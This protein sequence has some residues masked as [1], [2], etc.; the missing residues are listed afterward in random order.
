MATPE[1]TAKLSESVKEMETW[2]DRYTGKTA[3]Y[4]YS[5][6]SAK[7]LQP[8]GVT[9]A[10]LQGTSVAAVRANTVGNPL[11]KIAAD[12]VTQ[13]ATQAT[14]KLVT[15]SF[16]KLN[17]APIQNATQAV[18]QAWAAYSNLGTEI[19]MELARNAAKTI[20]KNNDLRAN[21]IQSIQTDLVTLHNC[22][23]VILNS[24]PFL[25][26]LVADEVADRLG[27]VAIAL[28]FVALVERAE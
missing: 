1:V 4:V 24:S 9:K 15:D 11:A 27:A 12:T 21:L 20:V 26:K 18:F 16:K 7:K 13:L 14:N 6:D 19:A 23:M 8:D 2:V 28:A 25:D 17:L 3:N 10:K 22:C 5:L